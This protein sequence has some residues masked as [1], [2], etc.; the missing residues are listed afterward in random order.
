[1]NVL[2]LCLMVAAILP[3]LAKLPIILEIRKNKLRYD[4]HHPRHQQSQL[5]GLGA[6]AVAGHQNAFEAFP[7]FASAVLLCLVTG[8]TSAGVQVLAVYYILSRIAY[9]ILYLKDLDKWRSLVWFT[10]MGTILVM[11]GSTLG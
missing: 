5:T 10:G 3:Y 4:N 7:L 6:R 2:I 11:M 9:H 8:H 1:M